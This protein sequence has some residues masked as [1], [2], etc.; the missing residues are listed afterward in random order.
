MATYRLNHQPSPPD[1]RDFKVRLSTT[2]PS[3]AEAGNVDLSVACTTVKDQGQ[4]GACTAF[5]TVGAMEYMEKRWNQNTK[6]D[7]FSERFTYYVTRVDVAGWST[8]DSGAYLRDAIKSVVKYGTCREETFPFNGDCVQKPPSTSYTEAVKFKALTYATFDSAS[9]SNML[10]AVKRTLAAGYPVV[11]GFTC[12]AN[13]WD[14]VHGVV[15]EASGRVIGGHAVLLVGYDDRTARLKFKNSWTSAWGDQ[16]YGYL[17]YNFFL[18]GNVSDLWA[19]YTS[20]ADSKTLGVEIANPAQDKLVLQ[21][22]LLAVLTT[23]ETRIA[24]ATDKARV[25]TLFN[26]LMATHANNLKV[27]NV[28]LALR[29]AC[30]ALAT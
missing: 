22:K 7:I 26:E 28:V 12:Y 5:A 9:K 3:T 16:G 19:I 4:V 14:A 15:P 24:D 17:S 18:Q 11:G 8:E 21:Q 1:A 2:L 13:L 25:N 10:S 20:Q 27:L 23:V 29:T 6:G 30:R